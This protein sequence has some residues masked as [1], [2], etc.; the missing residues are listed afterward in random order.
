M[1]SISYLIDNKFQRSKQ[2]NSSNLETAY[3][4]HI[5]KNLALQKSSKPRIDNSKI[6]QTKRRKH[7]DSCD[8]FMHK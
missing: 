8:D 7:K 2:R 3:G 6:S 4:T 1:R 5:R